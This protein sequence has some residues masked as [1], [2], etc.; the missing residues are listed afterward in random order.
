MRKY[1]PSILFFG[2]LFL[3]PFGG[4]SNFGLAAQSLSGRITDAETGEPLPFAS[5]YVEQSKSGT[6]SNADGYFQVKLAPGTN[7]VVFQYLGYQTQVKT[8]R[9]SQ[10]L[11]VELS[12]EALDLT[13]VEVLSGGEDKSYSVI[14]R[15]IAKADYHLNQLDRFEADVYIKGTG[16]VNKIP[17]ILK[18]LAPKEDRKEIEETLDRPFTTESTSKIVYERPNTYKQEVEH[19]YQ[20]GESD[21]DAAPYIFTS[22]YEPLVADELVSPLSP[23]AFGYYKFELEGVFVDQDKLINK[24]KVIPRSRGEDVFEGYIY[25]VQDDW[26][27][28]S[29]DLTTYKL[30]FQIDIAQTFAEIQEHIWEPITTTVDA[31]GQ[32]FGIAFEFHY[33]STIS[34]YKLTLNPDIGGYVEVIDEKTQPEVAAKVKKKRRDVSSIEQ[35]LAEGGEITRKDLRRL[36]R[37]YE[38][39][40]RKQSDEPQVE[41]NYSFNMDSAKAV[42]DTAAWAA[43][44]PVPLT[45]LEVKGYAIADSLEKVKAEE[46][47]V[48][49]TVGF[50]TDTADSTLVDT[51]ANRKRKRGLRFITPFPDPIFNPVEGYAL[52]ARL[53]WRNRKKKFGFGVHPRYG[54][55]WD[56]IN[57]EGD[58]HFGRSGRRSDFGPE[59]QWRISGGQFLRQFDDRPAIEPWISTYTNLFTGRNFI[60]LYQREYFKVEYRKNFD[61]TFRLEVD[62]GFEDRQAVSN[63]ANNNWFGLGDEEAYAPNLP[64]NAER[65]VI[66]QVSDAA[67]IRVAATFRPGLKY[68]IENG[69]KRPIELSAPRVGLEFRQG[70]SDLL[71]SRA[72]FTALEASYEHRFSN[73]R[74]GDVDLLVRGGAFLNN[75]SVDFPDF[76]H[77]AGSELTLTSLDPI[78]SYRLLPYYLESTSEEYLEFYGHYQFRKFLLT[79]IWK[80][81]LMGLKEDLF[82]NYLYTPTSENYTEVGYSIDNIFRIFRLE[83][84][85]SFRD[86]SYHDFG[87]RFS[88]A[89][90]FGRGG[91]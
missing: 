76:K 69:R 59:P 22:F 33:L 71:D 83:F 80:L 89:S 1:L 60:R 25:I 7:R 28:H 86:F 47:A 23:K 16:K 88:V 51:T 49:V 78:G 26:S 43:R 74:K 56:K 54:F 40:E 85:T 18:A 35:T 68:E 38:R 82:V 62:A 90:T 53:G 50:G 27:L 45:A 70:I 19:I 8:V 17:G 79:H 12:S 87:V 41:S 11:D 55:G 61:P 66:G 32:I 81:H 31:D 46:P 2:L 29:L 14:R 30:G 75:S 5:I 6:A 72:D 36:M 15:A 42:R 77:F 13:E 48:K 91:N 9:G 57:V 58:V 73:G 65:G 67:T 20:I 10:N 34:N 52:G 64:I 44:R 3:I 24:I 4:S 21:F 37:E 39:E 84:V 63:S